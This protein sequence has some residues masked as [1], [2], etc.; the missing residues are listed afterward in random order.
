MKIKIIWLIFFMSFVPMLGAMEAKEVDDGM[1]KLKID[2]TKW[3]D[4]LKDEEKRLLETLDGRAKTA[5]LF[6]KAIDT[7]FSIAEEDVKKHPRITPETVAKYIVLHNIVVP[8]QKDLAP[9]VFQRD[10]E[11]KKLAVEATTYLLFATIK[12]SNGDTALHW[13]AEKGFASVCFALLEYGADVNAKN[14]K[15]EIPLHRAAANKDGSTTCQMLLN[16]KSAV[17]AVNDL[18][19]TPLFVPVRKRNQAVVKVLIDAGASVTV[20]NTSNATV[21]DIDPDGPTQQSYEIR[22]L[23]EK[24]KPGLIGQALSWVW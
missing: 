9:L 3:F 21:F 13:A 19:E 16:Y 23:L 22:T 11:D 7:I 15:R 2:D 14:L 10:E 5:K 12:D 17:D 24:N 4:K 18:G 8:D 6:V 1:Q 20:I